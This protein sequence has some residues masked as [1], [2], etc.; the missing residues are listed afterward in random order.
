MRDLGGAEGLTG[1]F[2]LP[3]QPALVH[4][5]ARQI[6]ELAVSFIDRRG[7]GRALLEHAIEVVLGRPLVGAA[8]V[9]VVASGLDLLEVLRHG[10]VQVGGPRRALHDGVL[11]AEEVLQLVLSRV[12]VVHHPCRDGVEVGALLPALIDPL[13]R[14]GVCGVPEILGAQEGRRASTTHG[15]QVASDDLQQPSAI[16]RVGERDGETLVQCVESSV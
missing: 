13:S 4:A 8:L 14:H 9:E 3:A 7:R 10:V 5:R 6:P 15:T 16:R 2:E 11:P 1:A 12:A